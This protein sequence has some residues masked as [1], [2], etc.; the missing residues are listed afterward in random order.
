MSLVPA[1]APSPLLLGLKLI[2]AAVILWPYFTLRLTL[3][4]RGSWLP[5]TEWPRVMK[6]QLLIPHIK[7]EFLWKKSLK[8]TYSWNTARLGSVTS[9][10][11][12]SER[13]YWH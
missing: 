7:E 11:C 2:G 3:Q 6:A 8:L 5:K 4:Q 1:N 9:V 12:L 13:W 10:A